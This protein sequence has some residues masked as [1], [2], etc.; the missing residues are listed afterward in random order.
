[1]DL[2]REG[3]DPLEVTLPHDAMISE[4][5]DA[6]CP[7]GVNSGYFPGG[8]YCYEKEF[9]LSEEEA[10]KS[11]VLHFEG[12]YQNCVVELNGAKVGQHRYGYT[13][14]DVDLT[15]KARPGKNKISV[16][17]DNSLEPNCR[18]YSGSGIYRPVTLWIREKVHIERVKVETTSICPPEIFVEVEIAGK[19]AAGGTDMEERPLP[20]TVE[21]YDGGQRLYVGTPGKIVL[22]ARNSGALRN[23]IFTPVWCAS[24]GMSRGFPL[25]SV[26]W[27]GAQK[28]ECR[29]TGSVCCCGADVSIMTTVFWGPANFTML[30]SGASEF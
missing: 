3:D 12:V 28:R 2:Y 14:F 19:D 9:V 11:V 10:S 7:N 5:R 29:S 27:S 24:Q 18:W 22:E 30:R 4:K 20:V 13:P 26:P 23:R 15:E 1:M 25:A 16:S 6:G 17:V 8:K 21:I